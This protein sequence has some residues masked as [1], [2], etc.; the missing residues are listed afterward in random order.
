MRRLARPWLA[1][2]WLGFMSVLAVVEFGMNW[3]AWLLIGITAFSVTFDVAVRRFFRR[4]EF[5]LDEYRRKRRVR[6]DA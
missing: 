6:R 5:D 4:T 2:A 1:N 3:F